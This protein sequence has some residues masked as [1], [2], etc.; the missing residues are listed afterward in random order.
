MKKLLCMAVASVIGF[1]AFAEGK[2]GLTFTVDSK[3]VLWSNAD[4]ADGTIGLYNDGSE[5]V[6]K[7]FQVKQGEDDFYLEMGANYE[8]SVGGAMFKIRANAEGLWNLTSDTADSGFLSLYRWEAWANPFTWLKVSVGNQPVELYAEGVRWD[9]L[10]GAGIFESAG[11]H[12]YAEFTP[13]DLVDGLT[14]AVGVL[15]STKKRNTL[16]ANYGGDT[17]EPLDTL[18]AW[19]TYNI[20]AQGNISVEYE[21][22]SEDLS[23]VPDGDVKRI[24]AQFDYNGIDNVEAILGYSAYLYKDSITD[25]A[26]M[27]LAQHRVDFDF[28]LTNE[29]Y[30]FE[31]FNEAIIRNKDYGS[32]GD[33]AALKF[34][35]YLDNLTPWIRVNYYKNY[36]DNFN[37]G[38]SSSQFWD[39]DLGEDGTGDPSEWGLVVEPRVTLDLGK[40]IS[41]TLGI[42]IRYASFDFAC[43]DPEKGEYDKFAWAIPLQVTVNF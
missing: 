20:A 30:A 15:N 39:F 8:T 1:T 13:T 35:Y 2:G 24:G 41:T 33:R 29:K 17:T 28:R 38:W 32:F 26:K 9:A 23:G 11:N 18:A 37:P 5:G 16:P 43:V 12:I 6:K 42:D 34:E 14:F 21:A 27:E 22:M 4:V 36:S 3:A 10:S 40:G 25:G 19:A 7:G 31:F